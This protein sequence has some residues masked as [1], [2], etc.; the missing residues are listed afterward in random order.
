MAG[1]LVYVQKDLLSVTNGVIVHGENCQLRMGAGVAK[2]I[3]E[4]YPIVLQRL[5]Q[6]NVKGPHLLGTIHTVDV[7]P[8]LLVVS[9]FSQVYYGRMKI[10]Y[11]SAVA[12]RKGFIKLFYILADSQFAD[13]PIYLPKIGAGLGGLDWESEVVPE[14]E[15]AMQLTGYSHN[16][17]VCEYLTPRQNRGA[18]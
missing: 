1:K 13:Q 17:T 18:P 3:A 8:T 10:K 14:L 2:A 4:K 9:L 12:I 7:T 5:Q 16:L 15:T 6:D 11:A